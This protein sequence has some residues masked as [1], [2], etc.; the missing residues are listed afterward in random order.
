MLPRG[1]FGRVGTFILWILLCIGAAWGAIVMSKIFHAEFNLTDFRNAHLYLCDCTDN[2]N[3][4]DPS[5]HQS[6]CGY[7]SWWTRWSETYYQEGGG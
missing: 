2:G 7:V 3:H 4:E 5:Y 1:Y 6:T